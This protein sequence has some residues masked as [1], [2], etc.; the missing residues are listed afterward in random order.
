MSAKILPMTL[1]ALVLAVAALM[2]GLALGQEP[3]IDQVY[4]EAQS[5]NLAEAQSMVDGVLRTHPNSAKAHFVSAELLA[6]QGRF[7]QAEVELRAA[8]RLEPQLPFT[9]PQAVQE[10]E[11]RI[12]GSRGASSGVV[13]APGGAPYGI[14]AVAPTSGGGIPWLTLFVITGLVLLFVVGIQAVRRRNGTYLPSGPPAGYG[15]AAPVPASGM[16]AQAPMSGGMGSGILG[17]LATGAAVGAGMVAGEAL[18][19]RFTEG[20][21]GSITNPPGPSGEQ[22]SLA[23]DDIGGADFGISDGGSW[24]DNLGGGGSDWS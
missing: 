8:Q 13:M 2:V 21:G 18:A 23:S 15:A 3:T 14:R 9:T 10:L 6:R 17:G 19:H 5:G 16:G 4:R 22:P 1:G 20:H 11:R 24:D 12:A 7:A